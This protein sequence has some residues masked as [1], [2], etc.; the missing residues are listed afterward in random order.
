MLDPAA[1]ICMDCSMQLTHDWLL[2]NSVYQV[3]DMFGS[4]LPVC[5][6]A[7]SCINELVKD[8]Q[9]GLLFSSPQELAAALQRLLNDFP[10]PLAE[11]STMKDSMKDMPFESWEGAWERVVLPVVIRR[12]SMSANH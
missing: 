3:V 4:G 6:A 12:R 7:Y 9:N 2:S 5:A 1:V 8:G 10:S 11:C